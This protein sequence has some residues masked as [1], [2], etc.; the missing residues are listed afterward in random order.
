MGQAQVIQTN[1]DFLTKVKFTYERT[2]NKKKQRDVTQYEYRCL[3]RYRDRQHTRR[4]YLADGVE[5]TLLDVLSSLF[6]EASNLQGTHSLVTFATKF[7][8]PL[9]TVNDLKAAEKF[10]NHCKHS[11]IV[12]E[13]LFTTSEISSF[14]AQ[15]S[16]L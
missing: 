6:L 14:I 12:L 1:L 10:Y 8:R 16:Y 5:P 13:R 11:R 7:N 15:A 9:E 3:I 2:G 4:I